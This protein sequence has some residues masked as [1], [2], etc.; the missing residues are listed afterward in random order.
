MGQLTFSFDDLLAQLPE[1]LP[2]GRRGRPTWHHL[3]GLGEVARKQAPNLDDFLKQPIDGIMG[4]LHPKRKEELERYEAFYASE[5]RGKLLLSL[6]VFTP[7]PDVALPESALR[8]RIPR[9]SDGRL[10]QPAEA[11]YELRA[12][13]LMGSE[14][15]FRS[16]EADAGEM[17]LE[18]AVEVEI[19]FVP[20]CSNVVDAGAQ[21]IQSPDPI[22]GHDK[23]LLS[24]AGVHLSARSL[25]D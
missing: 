18:A 21:R 7:S 9:P 1:S 16:D 19:Q 8:R 12:A 2:G 24:Q 14:L 6:D 22:P 20:R 5:W 25:Y 15:T 17:Y 4:L 13:V 10:P 23:E 3:Y 11:E